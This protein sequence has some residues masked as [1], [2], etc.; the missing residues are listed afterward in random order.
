MASGRCWGFAG[1]NL[2]RLQVVDSLE[3]NT[4]EFHKIISCFG[5]S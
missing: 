5:I 3:L 2:M 1:L 4:F